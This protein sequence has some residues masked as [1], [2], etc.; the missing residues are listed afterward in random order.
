MASPPPRRRGHHETT[1]F[2]NQWVPSHHVD[3]RRGDAAAQRSHRACKTDAARQT[4]RGRELQLA[5][6]FASA[7]FYASVYTTSMVILSSAVFASYAEF[8]WHDL[9][10]PLGLVWMLVFTVTILGGCL[11]FA[12]DWFGHHLDKIHGA[13]F[14]KMYDGDFSKC[15]LVIFLSVGSV[16]V[17]WCQFSG[18]LALDFTDRRGD[19][20]TPMKGFGDKGSM[21][22]SG[23]GAC[24]G[25][26]CVECLSSKQCK[27]SK[28]MRRW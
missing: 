17:F 1:Y 7:V 3:S 5:I 11:L 23:V 12:H 24:Q 27:L 19:A 21:F 9:F 16:L 2:I 13:V 20:A 26:N 18:V 25:R 8:I 6:L 28:M 15:E 10:I 14:M 4:R 22:T